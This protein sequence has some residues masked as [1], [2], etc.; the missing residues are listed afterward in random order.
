M[1]PVFILLAL[2]LTCCVVRDLLDLHAERQADE[3]TRQD[4]QS[5]GPV[6]IHRSVT[7]AVLFWAA[8][9]WTM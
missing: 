5:R 2:I 1:A 7:F 6:M 3:R 9:I 4:M 8:A